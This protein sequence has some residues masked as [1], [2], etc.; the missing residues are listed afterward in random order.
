MP[1]VPAEEAAW[2]AIEALLVEAGLPLDG[3][4]GA[5]SLGVVAREGEQIVGAAAVESYGSIGLLRSV[6][7]RPDRRGTG[8]GAAL[9]DAAEARARAAGIAELYLLTDSAERFFGHRGYAARSR[10][11]APAPIADSVE[12]R[13]ACADTAVLMARALGDGS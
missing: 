7:V 8:L 6:V 12:F 13:V 10:S 4:R 11:A 9:V 1:V 5:F 3:A 2:P